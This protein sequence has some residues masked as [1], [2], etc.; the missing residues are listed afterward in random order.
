MNCKRSIS[1]KTQSRII[2]KL[3][4]FVKRCHPLEYGRLIIEIRI[5]VFI[6]WSGVWK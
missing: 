6:Q 5:D 3:V 1:T 2:E 4:F